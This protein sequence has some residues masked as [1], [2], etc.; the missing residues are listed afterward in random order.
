MQASALQP[1]PLSTPRRARLSTRAGW[2]DPGYLPQ[3]VRQQLLECLRAGRIEGEKAEQFANSCALHAERVAGGHWA[4]T[5]AQQRTELQALAAAA[6]GLRD[7]IRGARRPVFVDIELQAHRAAKVAGIGLQAH[8]ARLQPL[9]EALRQLASGCD[10][11]AILACAAGDAVEVERSRMVEAE[12]GE[13]LVHGL[14]LAYRAQFATL[15]PGD[16]RGWF[17]ALCK[18]LGDQVGFKCGPVIV[19]RA[20]ANVRDGIS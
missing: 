13:G 11:L 16:K 4:A 17:A 20:L 6:A 9:D 18:T 12:A 7:A 8:A 19:Q 15:P 10:S 14:I 2:C 3:D 5:P 1:L